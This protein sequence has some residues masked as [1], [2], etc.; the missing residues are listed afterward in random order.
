M[1]WHMHPICLTGAWWRAAAALL[2]VFLF[3]D[4][5]PEVAARVAVPVTRL[6]RVV[7]WLWL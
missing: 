2:L 6:T 4:W 1:P 7:V 5:P 3:A